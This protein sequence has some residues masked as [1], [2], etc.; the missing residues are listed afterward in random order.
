VES[1]RITM[2]ALVA[3]PDG[4][5]VIRLAGNSDDPEALAAQLAQQVQEQGSNALLSPQPSVLSPHASRLTPLHGR[6][7]VV[8]RAAHQAQE[9]CDRLREV[10]AYPIGIPAI[11][12]QPIADN[13][14][15]EEAIGSI[16]QY[17]WLLFT[18]A[19]GVDAFWQQLAARQYT[20]TGERLRVAAV[21]PVTAAA[22]VERGIQS[23]V[24]PDSFTGE[25]LAA[26][27]GDLRDRRALLVQAAA[28]HPHTA[29]SLLAQGAIVTTV[30]LYDTIA[31]EP[32]ETALA[33]LA[34][35]VDAITFAS[36]SA[37]R[38]FAQA[39]A[40]RFPTLLA[41]TV[42]ACIGPSTA[43]VVRELG[44]RP[45][46]IAEEHT[47][48]GLTTALVAYFNRPETPLS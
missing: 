11:A 24:V 7:I 35:G 32:D 39:L 26:G 31:A 40:G 4:R 20:I 44:F 37:A 36:G 30:P 27:L 34:A 2:E 3:S 42:I 38:S 17:D 33:E 13:R 46:V 25:A 16:D 10:G 29:E 14:P 23:A 47:A 5:R 19:N 15:L 43:E 28:A 9:L 45:A 48:E 6:R 12:I 1:G 18:S 21:G 41:E 22:L 8:T